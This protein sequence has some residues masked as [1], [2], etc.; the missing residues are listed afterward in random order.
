[1]KRIFMVFDEFSV[2]AGEQVLN[3]VNMGRGK[4]VH[5]IFGTQGLADLDRVDPGFKS[6]VM[7]CVN[8]IICHRINDQESAESVTSWI[9]TRDAFVLSTQYNPNQTDD[10]VG[11]V[12]KTKEFIVHPDQIKQE[13]CTGEAYFVSKVGR[14]VVEKVRVML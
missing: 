13:L 3:L 6:Q 2:F 12:G 14:F 11:T 1:M 7:N 10:G 8:S 9:G 4:G 5:A